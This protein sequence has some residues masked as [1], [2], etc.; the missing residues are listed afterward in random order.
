V[1]CVLYVIK[2]GVRLKGRI[3]VG[4]RNVLIKVGNTDEMR[5]WRRR[6]DSSRYQRNLTIF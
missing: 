4:A 2:N 5:K 1:S 3:L 6:K